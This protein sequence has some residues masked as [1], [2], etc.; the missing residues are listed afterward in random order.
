MRESADDDID[1]AKEELL[2]VKE[3]L[4]EAKKDLARFEKKLQKQAE[5]QAETKDTRPQSI[6][7]IGG[8]KLSLQKGKSIEESISLNT[9][10]DVNTITLVDDHGKIKVY[11]T[12]TARKYATRFG[13]KR[14]TPNAKHR[15]TPLQK[16]KREVSEALSKISAK[17][18][19][20]SKVFVG[21]HAEIKAKMI[22]NGISEAAVNKW[23]RKFGKTAAAA[24][25]SKT[26]TSYINIK[27]VEDVND[28]IALWL[29]ESGGHHGIRNLIDAKDLNPL[30]DNVWK[31][32]VKLAETDAEMKS[33]MDDI[34][35]RYKG[36]DAAG[37]GD[38]VIAVLAE[39]V[40]HGKLNSVT[41]KLW[42]DILSRFQKLLKQ[43]IGDPVT[44]LSK[45]Q[46]EDIVLA[47]VQSNFQEGNA[48]RMI[49]GKVMQ[50]KIIQHKENPKFKKWFNGSKVVDKNGDPLMVFHGTRYDFD[51]FRIQEGKRYPSG[52]AVGYF[53]VNPEYS[54]NFN[55]NSAIGYSRRSRP[56]TIPVFLSIKKPFDA[57]RFSIRGVNYVDVESQLKRDGIELTDKQRKE[58]K[59]LFKRDSDPFWRHF[60]EYT[61]DAKKLFK[62]LGYD[63]VIQVENYSP[64]GGDTKGNQSLVYVAFEQNQIKSATGNNGNFDPN[65]NSIQNQINSGKNELSSQLNNDEKQQNEINPTGRSRTSVDANVSERPSS[66]A[67]GGERNFTERSESRTLKVGG[68]D[69]K[70]KRVYATSQKL[71][72]DIKRA[73]PQAHVDSALYEITD[74]KAFRDSIQ[75]A[76][77][78]NAFGAAV[79]VYEE[80]EY[81]DM[82]LFITEDGASGVAIK[83]NGDLVSGFSKSQKGKKFRIAQ[84]LVLAVENGATKADAFDTVLPSYYTQFGFEAVSRQKWDDQY[85]PEGWD[86]KV[87]EKWNNGRPDVVYFVYTGGDRA[88]LSERVGTFP[89][90]EQNG[91]KTTP[92]VEE[93]DAAAKAQQDKI[94]N[95]ELADEGFHNKVVDP[96]TEALDA[97]FAGEAISTQ[98]N[99]NEAKAL[100]TVADRARAI[101]QDRELAIRRMMEQ[102]ER[103]IGRKIPKNLNPYYLFTLKAGRSEEM[104]S[105]FSDNIQTPLLDAMKVITKKGAKAKEIYHYMIA[106]HAAERNRYLRNKAVEK[107]ARSLKNKGYSASEQAVLIADK[108]AEIAN[109]DFSGAIELAKLQGLD[110]SVDIDMFAT[111]YAKEFEAKYG[112]SDLDRVWRRVKIGT[113]YV[114]DRQL[115]SGAI[116]LEL[117]D[118]LKTRYRNYVP[119]RGWENAADNDFAYHSGRG[120]G[121]SFQEAEGRKSLSYNPV[122][123][124]MSMAQKSIMEQMDTEIRIKMLDFIKQQPKG[125]LDALV[126]LKKV[127]YRKVEVSD[128]TYE[129]M[130]VTKTPTMKELRDG[131]VK[132]RIHTDHQ[133][134]RTIREA[135]EHEVLVRTED[136][137][138][139]MVFK[140]PEVAQAFNHENSLTMLTMFGKRK[141]DFDIPNKA[142]GNSIG[143]FTNKM[144]LFM[145][146]WNMAFA[147]ANA[148]RD[149]QL[150]FAVQYMDKGMGEAVNTVKQLRKAHRASRRYLMGTAKMSDPIDKMY[151]EFREIGGITGWTH[152]MTPEQFT[153]KMEKEIKHSLA[154]SLW[155]NT[156]GAAFHGYVKLAEGFAGYFEDGVRFA[157][158]MNARQQN[159]S[160]EEAAMEAKEITVNF[161]R[162]GKA[163]KGADALYAFVNPAIQG[164]QRFMS[165]A[166][167]SP[168]RASAVL[169]FYVA[170]GALTAMLGDMMSP[171][172]NENEEDKTSYYNI[173]SWMRHNYVTIPTGDKYIS[174]PV[175]QITRG[176]FGIGATLYDWVSGNMDF[177]EAAAEMALGVTSSISPIDV[178]GVYKDG[179]FSSSAIIPTAIRPWVELAENK[180][181]QGRAIMKEGFTKKID[182]MTADHQRH[183]PYANSYITG[184]TDWIFEA[185]H[186]VKS[187]NKAI[188]TKNGKIKKAK[189]YADIN[190]AWIEHLYKSYLGGTGGILMDLV[191]TGT[192]MISPE[193]DV[194]LKQIPI[195]QKF[196]RNIPDE[197][198][199]YRD[200]FMKYA[201][202]YD[203]L[204]SELAELEENHDGKGISLL[205]QNY[206]EFL[207]IMD[208]SIKM[209]NE[210]YKAIRPAPQEAKDKVGLVIDKFTKE[211][212]LKVREI[213]ERK[214]I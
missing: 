54:D 165:L 125:K 197:K 98:V 3:E 131:D 33:L 75:E 104:F 52:D 4:K 198:Y 126:S 208:S 107:Y 166:K 13:Y 190:P 5:K 178:G 19:N 186:D 50:S 123:N 200:E 199:R 17:A 10:G 89:S 68:R 2:N 136:G 12:D 113:D 203:Y 192:A 149:A 159:R 169:G 155:S 53:A 85:S 167:D 128:G 39:R 26:N 153:R 78:S 112:K 76:K 185:L 44:L 9:D 195:A 88:S 214:D 55:G 154:N 100:K 105:Q 164:V 18:V 63:G 102:A 144:K 28:A 8:R 87:F 59:L 108:T 109:E 124:I 62:E 162:K 32:T 194:Q 1:Y 7:V 90:W 204:K 140:D 171:E 92:Y 120:S 66:Q 72:S 91:K 189:N 99:H 45:K 175:A 158:Y 207:G 137:D 184:V 156:V 23:S 82:R 119:L 213:K 97:M 161:N 205:Y 42:S 133:R 38:E 151:Q 111:N 181:Y 67:N 150:M 212:V 129:W 122:A 179:E 114:L 24:Y 139:S 77:N 21:S 170:L 201:Q 193:K 182:E 143:R 173:S 168:W 48:K 148:V 25:N 121:K 103:L 36:L 70:V 147:P 58:L 210:T 57:S 84:L 64:R 127:Y 86:Y 160:V 49:D 83:K 177:D 37:K 60:R 145:T 79:Y 157:V 34:N 94:D 174:I 176:F 29:H 14:N 65:D 56:S 73:F 95:Q 40:Q 81:V 74:A 132:L 142:L 180:D 22:E 61:Q 138:V 115:K 69:V 43:V 211:M 163:T 20:G 80:S 110:E 141:F 96:E 116:S 130:P 106:K 30:L 41:Q 101:V 16:K 146:S 187:T 35:I 206:G 118:Q 135:S 11:S 209:R 6:T 71:S 183:Y 196:V 172:D 15:E 191:E 51:T 134:L 46:I 152:Q 188:L 93:W 31:S 27:M 47:S 117:Y 202:T